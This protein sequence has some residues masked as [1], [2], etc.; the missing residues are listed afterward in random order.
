MIAKDT[1]HPSLVDRLVE[2]ARI[3]HSHR[4]AITSDRQFPSMNNVSMR[5]DTYAHN[6]LRDG[7]ST[8][9]QY[10]PYWVV[11][12]IN[13][14]IILLVP[15]VV[16]LLPMLRAV[17]RVYAWRIRGRV[18]RYYDDIKAIDEKVRSQ[19]AA[20][21]LNA[22]NEELSQIDQQLADLELPLPYSEYSY[23]ARLHIDL[24]RKRIEDRL[25]KPS[26]A[27]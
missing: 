20:D 8:L 26:T 24:V 25:T 4:D 22:L 19:S 11:A 14:F 3:V 5:Q 7:T 12:Q 1:L 17:P 10:L 2:A 6:L 18:Y 13:R 21:A 9:A 23:T 15:V 27:S 16:L